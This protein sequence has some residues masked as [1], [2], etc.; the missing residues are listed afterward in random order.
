MAI[1]NI[2]EYK[3][4]KEPHIVSELICLSCLYRW[5]AAFPSAVLLKNL[6]C[7]SCGAVNKIIKTGQDLEAIE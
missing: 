5:I 7:P 4:S 2:N 6:E 1:V 3:E